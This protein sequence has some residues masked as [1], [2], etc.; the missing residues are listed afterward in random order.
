MFKAGLKVNPPAWRRGLLLFP[1]LNCA[2]RM[3]VYYFCEKGCVYLLQPQKIQKMQ[4]S[5]YVVN[6]YEQ[7]T[8][9]FFKRV[10]YHKNFT[11]ALLKPG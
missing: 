6:I 1:T 4:V 2:R 7:I 3:N 9:K 10:I 11:T 8:L 5:S